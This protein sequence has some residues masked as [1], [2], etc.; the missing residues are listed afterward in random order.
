MPRRAIHG[1]PM[2]YPFLASMRYGRIA[3]VSATHD[4][5][6]F[7]GPHESYMRQYIIKC[8]F[9]RTQPAWA[10]IDTSGGYH[11]GAMN[12]QSRP[13]ILLPIQYSPLSY[14]CHA[15][16]HIKPFYQLF[17]LSTF[18]S[19]TRVEKVLNLTS[20]TNHS[21][22]TEVLSAKHSTTNGFSTMIGSR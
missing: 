15:W 17:N 1:W 6:K 19:Q 7:V 14:N 9:I 13:L 18:Q 12:L 4:A 10:L 2:H 20:G 11:L 16:S 8:L 3:F 21:T 5:N 22:S